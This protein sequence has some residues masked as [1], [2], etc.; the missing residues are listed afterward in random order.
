MARVTR[1]AGVSRRTFYEVFTDR[2]DCFLALFEDARA[3]AERIVLA[4][5]TDARGGDG[6]GGDWR[7]GVRAGLRALLELFD[8]EPRLATL[9][10]VD[11]LRGGERVLARRALALGELGEV[12]QGIASGAHKSAA[13]QLSELTGEGVVGGVLAV[14]HARLS[15]RD[16]GSL[17]GL[18]NSLMAMVVLP[19]LG[20]AAARQEL[21]RPLEVPVAGKPATGTTGEAALDGAGLGSAPGEME[22]PEGG[23]DGVGAADPLAGLPMR[24]TY[25]T[26]RVLGA[27]AQRPGASNRVV[28]ELAGV[29][30]QGQI[31]K[32][33]ARLERLGLIENGRRTRGVRGSDMRRGGGSQRVA[34]E[35]NAWCLTARGVEV[36][37]ALRVQGNSGNVNGG[38]VR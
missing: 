29:P 23:G 13:P 14:L 2:E 15:P 35:A 21:D 9:L 36:E 26:L 38:S 28:G 22:P 17:Y 18:V 11:A 19:Y 20:A 37:R 4:A 31:S 30:D 5:Y 32:L 16:P 1:G 3:R 12:I 6:D 25:R 24:V 10:I 33:L 34:G 27:L 8:S 7:T